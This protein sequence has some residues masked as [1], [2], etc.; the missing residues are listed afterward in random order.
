MY[1]TSATGLHF[2]RPIRWVVAILGGKTLKVPLGGR[3][4]GELLLGNRFL[5]KDRIPVSVHSDYLK[6]KR[7]ILY[8]S[9][10]RT[11]R[12]RLKGN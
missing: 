7:P 12:K 6:V 9:G 3:C 11:A 8:G 5:G 2:Y 4:G 1:W 10:P